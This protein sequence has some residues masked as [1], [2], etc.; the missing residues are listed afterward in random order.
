M[1][2]DRVQVVDTCG[3]LNIPSQASEPYA[4][5]WS[6][7]A[8][9]WQWSDLMKQKFS[10]AALLVGTLALAGCAGFDATSGGDTA[11][12]PL[13]NTYWKL[14]TV[15]EHQAVTI[16]EAREAHLVLHAEDAR[17]AGSTGCNRMMGDYERDGDRLTFDQVAT[18]MMACPGEVMELEREFL[19]ALGEIAS[20]QV[21]A[22]NLT[23]LDDE[24]EARAR[25]EAVHL[26]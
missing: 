11:N 13:E 26:Y 4:V 23:L 9:E 21:E 22:E 10:L 3:G 5:G 16:D 7:K 18:T 24:G 19:D 15:G 1:K 2:R 17:L 25:F 6:E 12:E 14:V 20:W 8:H